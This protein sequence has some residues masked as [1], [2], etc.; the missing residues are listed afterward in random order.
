MMGYVDLR[1]KI[2]YP[3]SLSYPLFNIF[4][5]DPATGL[6]AA[7]NKDNLLGELKLSQVALLFRVLAKY[8]VP[9]V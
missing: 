5:Y 8:S 7:R 9:M 3:V 1:G 2:F 6:I 4:V